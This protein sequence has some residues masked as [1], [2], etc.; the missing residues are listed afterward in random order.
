[1]RPAPLRSLTLRGLALLAG[2]GLPLPTVAADAAVKPAPAATAPA[3]VNEMLKGAAAEPGAQV[4]PSG[5]VLR[6]LRAGQGARPVH[7]DRVRVHYRGQLADGTEFDSSYRRGEPAE[8]PLSR[9]IP[10]W[11][12]GVSRLAVGSRAVLTCPPNLAYGARGA[13]GVIPPNATLRFEVELM[14][15]VR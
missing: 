6:V 5:L 12:E 1:M 9:V 2:A 8:F 7:T 14:S 13:G 10:C 11:T 3:P 4:L 15:I